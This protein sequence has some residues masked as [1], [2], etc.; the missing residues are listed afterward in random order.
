MRFLNTN[1]DYEFYMVEFLS[2]YIIFNKIQ[3]KPNRNKQKQNKAIKSPKY[4]KYYNPT[5]KYNN[6]NISS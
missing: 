5:L 2:P 4:E 6:Q 3:D 1:L